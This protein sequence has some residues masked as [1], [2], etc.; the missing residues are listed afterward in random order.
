MELQENEI[1]P[2]I[3][4]QIIAHQ[5]ELDRYRLRKRK[6]FEGLIRQVGWNLR[7]WIKY[8]RWEESQPRLDRAR[9]IW[10]R[11]LERFQYKDSMLWLKYAEFE[12]RN[13]QFSRAR[14]VWGRAV[15]LLPRVDQLWF[16]YIQMEKMLSNVV[17]ARQLF[18]MWM[19]WIPDQRAWLAYIK[20]ELKCN[21]ISR[22]REIF[23][24]FISCHSTI[25]AWIRY[26]EFEINNGQITK[27][28]NIFE[29]AVDKFADDREAEQL[30][31]SFAKFEVLC[32]ETE[33]ARCLLDR[34]SNGGVEEVDVY[35][36]SL[37]ES[38]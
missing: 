30:F 33:R 35:G 22:A 28:R 15:A 26:A 11:A 20:F 18:K 9:S 19:E 1:L 17:G 2:P 12:M 38:C 21:E 3:Q 37:L 32:N 8:A 10:E 14:G 7:V 29:R 24:R 31:V 6:E 23:E 16:K 34:I 36:L 13:R 5:R 27:T 4:I 25:G